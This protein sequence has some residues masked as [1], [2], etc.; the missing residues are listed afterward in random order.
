MIKRNTKRNTKKR[1]TKRRLQRGGRNGINGEEETKEMLLNKVYDPDNY[2][3]EKIKRMM[4]KKHSNPPN[5]IMWGMTFNNIIDHE[6]KR[7]GIKT[8][9][10]YYNRLIE[11]KE[12]AEIFS[13]IMQ[14]SGN[15]N[16][17]KPQVQP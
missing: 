1:N 14:A 12:E 10:E 15:A 11:E 6:M 5:N 9:E 8:Y 7:K 13:R 17:K 16:S 3:R 2:W 4:R